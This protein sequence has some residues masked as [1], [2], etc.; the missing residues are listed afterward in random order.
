MFVKYYARIAADLGLPPDSS[1]Q[2]VFDMLAELESWTRKQSLV[3]QSR[4]FSWNESAH[5]HLKEFWASRMLLEWYFDGEVDP[6]DLSL[7][8]FKL[9]RESL[10]GLKLAFK[11]LSTQ[12]FESSCIVYICSQPCWSWYTNQVQN[13]KTSMDNLVYQ[14]SMADE[15]HE[16][17]HLQELAGFLNPIGAN[18]FSALFYST[19]D[20]NSLASQIVTYVVQLL[21]QRA[22]SLSKHCSPPECY[23][24]FLGPDEISQLAG[25]QMRNDL[26]WLLTLEMSTAPEASNLAS[27]CRLSCDA[28]TRLA[29]FL[30]SQHMNH[31]C[32][33]VLTALLKTLPDAK[34]VEDCHQ[35]VRTAQKSRGNEKLTTTTV[36]ALIQNS[37]V[38]TSRRLKHGSKITRETFMTDYPRAKKIIVNKI[39]NAR[40]HKL[41]KSFG[42]IL[43][44]RDWAS[45]TEPNLVQ[46]AA[47]WQWLRHYMD[48]RLAESGVQLQD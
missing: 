35:V 5:T 32:K 18:S 11:C 2:Q 20:E 36:Q 42:D 31:Q 45:L 24:G 30:K 19:F 25:Q 1:A 27:D 17:E 7:G 33:L 14:K 6:D 47:G 10:G 9:C 41:P 46:S 16:E 44:R 34:I 3:K 48:Q 22:G 40:S 38:L 26:K 21:S 8:S 29:L 4:W 13:V 15:W 12:V 28:P 39:F 23:A 37:K 43:A